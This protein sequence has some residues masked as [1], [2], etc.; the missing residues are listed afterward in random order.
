MT[1]LIATI[2]LA[3][4]PSDIC[5]GP[6]V[7]HPHYPRSVEMKL[8]FRG[9]VDTLK[10]SH[11]TVTF[12]RDGFEKAKPGYSWHL[13]NGRLETSRDITVGGVKLEAGT[14]SIKA[15]KREDG[16]WELIAD[17]AGRFQ[18]RLTDEARALKTEFKETRE[19]KEHM[20]IDIHPHGAKDN[21]KLWLEV[22]MDR[23]VARSLVDI[24]K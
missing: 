6:I 19:P 1:S 10:V 14:Y 12:N 23:Y 5:P 3:A 11:L 20:T 18:A 13:A 22:H 4:A 8:G 2:I 15:R 24:G 17:K 16:K 7:W 21:T 9:D